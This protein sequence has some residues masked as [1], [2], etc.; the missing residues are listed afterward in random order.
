MYCATCI[1]GK[2]QVDL[3]Q[4]SLWVTY[5]CLSVAMDNAERYQNSKDET[6]PLIMPLE[7]NPKSQSCFS[8]KMAR[9]TCRTKVQE[10][11]NAT[12][13]NK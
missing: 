8:G 10:K 13:E 7:W 9:R 6:E 4:R 5:I 1:C 11:G 2:Q 3:C 12:R